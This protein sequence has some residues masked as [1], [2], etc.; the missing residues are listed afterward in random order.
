MTL[1]NFNTD[2]VDRLPT[3]VFASPQVQIITDSATLGELSLAP[4]E[5]CGVVIGD[6]SRGCLF[7]RLPNRSDRPDRHFRIAPEDVG[8]LEENRLPFTAVWHSHPPLKSGPGRR[9]AE[10]DRQ[11]GAAASTFDLDYHPI[12]YRLMI[13]HAGVLR[14]F[15]LAGAVIKEWLTESAVV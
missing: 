15:D 10:D 5:S 9:T 13:I 11:A 1:I 2:F 3:P 12:D 4:T 8:L 14:E 6:P 7:L